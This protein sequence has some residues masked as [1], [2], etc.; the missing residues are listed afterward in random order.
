VYD[1]LQKEK[2]L[3]LI[4]LALL[5]DVGDGDHTSLASIPADRVNTAQLLVKDQGVLAGV[6]AAEWVCEE[7]DTSLQFEK[8][9]ND[10][11][12]VKHGD[13]AFTI[14]GNS[15][16]ILQAER[17]LLNI[18][19]RM[20]GIATY[21]H[22]LAAKI[23]HTSTKLLDTRK[24]TPNFRMFEKWAVKIGGGT[25][26]R[27]GLFDMIL[28]KDNHVDVAGGVTKALQNTQTYLLHSGKQL[29]VEIEVRNLKELEEVLAFGTVKRVMF[30]NMALAD[31]YQAVKMV[32][33]KMETEISGG[34]TEDT[35][36]PLA[37]TG[38]DYISAG[39]LT[40]A[41]KS[42]DLSLKAI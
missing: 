8:K 41:V 27:Y 13:V 39:K 30:D 36:V 29:D 33:G 12:L 2:A 23:A 35:I 6:L 32:G 24:T 10:G 34:V 26:H 14:S 25:N 9:L 11:A 5:E 42:L 7:V 16:A 21:T 38:V 19:Q 22:F 17:L 18:M 40:H 3:E 4:R 31:I 37:E 1:Y 15:R 28:L 20:S